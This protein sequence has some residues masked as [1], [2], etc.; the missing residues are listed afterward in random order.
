[1]LF[2][3]GISGKVKCSTDLTVL[4][5]EVYVPQDPGSPEEEDIKEKKPSSQGKSSSKKETSKR[6]SKDKKDRG[7]T[8]VRGLV[9]P[10]SFSPQYTL[11]VYIFLD[12]IV[13]KAEGD[14]VYKCTIWCLTYSNHSI[15]TKW[16][17]FKDILF[18]NHYSNITDISRIKRFGKS[19]SFRTL[20]PAFMSII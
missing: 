3:P 18:W 15:Y 8:R 17:V 20:N 11:N 6:D 16:D 4:Q 19:D 7:V 1:M 13:V 2:R 14:N 10:P 12:R 9:N 5:Q